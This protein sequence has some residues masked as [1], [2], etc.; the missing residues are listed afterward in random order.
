MLRHRARRQLLAVAQS[1]LLT[2]VL[3]GK[4]GE[5]RVEA[6]VDAITAREMD[7]HSAAER[8]IAG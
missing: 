4:E 7:P 3:D 1:M 6:L 8:L 5:A 2:Q